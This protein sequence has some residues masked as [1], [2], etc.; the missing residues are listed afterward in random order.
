M[1]LLYVSKWYRDGIIDSDILGVTDNEA[2]RAIQMLL[3]DQKPCETNSTL[4]AVEQ[5]Y[6]PI[7][8]E[9]KSTVEMELLLL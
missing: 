7:L 6:I 9:K 1:M 8:Y 5:N 3:A 2:N 4:S